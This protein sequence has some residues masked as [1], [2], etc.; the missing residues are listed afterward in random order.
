MFTKAVCAHF[1]R[2]SQ[3]LGRLT[4]LRQTRSVAEF[5]TTFEQLAISNEGLYDE[6]YLE[7]FLSGLKDVIGAHVCMHHHVT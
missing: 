6:F 1:D 5:I 4:K 3:F 2:E 7:C